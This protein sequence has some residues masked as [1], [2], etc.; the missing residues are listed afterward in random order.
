MQSQGV[1]GETVE[2]CIN[3]KI[4]S[5][6]E[7]NDKKPQRSKDEA[8]LLFEDDGGFQESEQEYDEYEGANAFSPMDIYN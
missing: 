1:G 6:I 5:V 3:E 4:I 7:M 2:A 8:P